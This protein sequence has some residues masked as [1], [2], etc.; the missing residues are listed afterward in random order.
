MSEDVR[1]GD[2]E[3][4]F[5][6]VEVPGDPP[7]PLER[8]VDWTDQV[9]AFQIA[10]ALFPD[11]EAIVDSDGYCGPIA[12]DFETHLGLCWLLCGTRG[13]AEAVFRYLDDY[14]VELDLLPSLD[15]N[16]ARVYIQHHKFNFLSN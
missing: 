14:C 8:V 6:G 13:S 11:L 9:R 12:D 15:K 4:G 2:D 16:H 10:R 1:I 5:G 7:T 3:T